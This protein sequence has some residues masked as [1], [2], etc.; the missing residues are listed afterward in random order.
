MRRCRS[1]LSLALVAA[2]A[3]ASAG[4]A[5]GETR[6]ERDAVR[7]EQAAVAADLDVLA[8]ADADVAAALATLAANLATEQEALTAAEAQVALTEA[9]LA[10]ARAAEQ[11]LVD[12]ITE[13]EADVEFVA[14]QAYIGSGTNDRLGI[15]LGAEDPTEATQR[16]V[17]ADT[18]TTDLNDLL[19]RLETAREQLEV[20]RRAAQ[21]VAD[22]A[23]A[24]REDVR[25]RVAAL[26]VAREQHATLAAEV[27]ARIAARLA[28]AAAL[29]TL[30]EALSE[31]IRTREI[32]LARTTARSSG[33]GSGG[34]PVPAPPLRTVR[35]ITVHAD[36]AGLLDDLLIEAEEDGIDLGGGGYRDSAGQ[37]RLR[38][39]H[40]PD[41]VNSPPSAC[42]PPTAIPGTSNHERGLAVD[43]TTNGRVISSR[44]DPAFR[45]LEENAATFG[46]Y[47][48]PS[49]PWHWSVDGS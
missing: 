15:V 24:V 17:I 14:I 4:A 21:D 34:G 22:Q 6:E 18:V 2:L 31:Q 44:N 3:V 38:E 19:D 39:A 12:E 36:I 7:R 42:N 48:L 13:L 40:C 49:E 23:T 43:F 33:G 28:E 37:W 27:D 41:P 46:F 8:A 9:R 30:D 16:V 5:G 45:W 20:A 29:E 32:E 35:G 11:E 26:E 10:E 1:S 25:E 47:N